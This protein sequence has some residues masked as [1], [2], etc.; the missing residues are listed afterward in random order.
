MQVIFQQ[1]FVLA[2]QGKLTIPNQSLLPFKMCLRLSAL[3]G[4]LGQSWQLQ[5]HNHNYKF[6]HFLKYAV[7]L[8]CITILGCWPTWVTVSLEVILM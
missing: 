6:E 3:T 2:R 7:S 8:T 4:K 1:S 5:D